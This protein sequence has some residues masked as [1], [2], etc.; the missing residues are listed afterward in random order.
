[1]TSGLLYIGD[2]AERFND[3][4]TGMGAAAQLGQ[5]APVRLR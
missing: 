4:S 5:A 1:M 3:P 2:L